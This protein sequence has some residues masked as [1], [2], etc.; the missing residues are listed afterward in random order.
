M[1]LIYGAI[2]FYVNKNESS[3]SPLKNVHICVEVLWLVT[4]RQLG[5][6]Q[7]FVQGSEV[8]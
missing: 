7:P 6:S 2:S 3:L 4:H 1:K 5:L 8:M